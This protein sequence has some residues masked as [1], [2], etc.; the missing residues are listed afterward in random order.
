[1][2]IFILNWMRKNKNKELKISDYTEEKKK[3]IKKKEEAKRMEIAEAWD[4]ILYAQV[5]RGFLLVTQSIIRKYI[6]LSSLIITKNIVRILLFQSPEWSEDL[7]DWNR[8]MYIKCTYNGVP[9]SETEFPKNWLTEGIQIKVLFPFRLK[10]WHRYRSKLR[11]PQK[12]KNPMKKKVK[13]M[14]FFFFIYFPGIR[15]EALRKANSI[16]AAA[17][18]PGCCGA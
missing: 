14:D 3:E 17:E 2:K 16:R 5:I 4:N 8:E 13:K 12:E 7:K 15:S 11:S 18:N 1:M 9:L 10:P 6:L